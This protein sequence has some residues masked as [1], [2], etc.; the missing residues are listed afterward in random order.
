MWPEE[1]Q[2][3]LDRLREK[4]FAGTL[5]SDEQEQLE[6]LFAELDRE[7]EEALRPAMERS[8]QRERE[9]D[10]EIARARRRIAAMEALAKGQERLRARAQSALDELLKEQ[11]AL[12][13][14]YERMAGEPM[15]A[16]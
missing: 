1:K 13:T 14:E 7:E 5:T 16:A 8:L 15:R 9:L 6:Q 4:E 2:Q 12:Q 10:E 11:E 3:L